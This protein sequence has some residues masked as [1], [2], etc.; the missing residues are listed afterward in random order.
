[1]TVF[2]PIFRG[3]RISLGST[4]G[5][6]LSSH[7]LDKGWW[8][9][10]VVVLVCTPISNIDEIFLSHIAS[11]G[12][13]HRWRF[14]LFEWYKTVLICFSPILERLNSSSCIDWPSVPS[15]KPLFPLWSLSVSY[16]CL[17]CRHVLTDLSFYMSLLLYLF[18]SNSSLHLPVCILC[19]CFFKDPFWCTEI[20]HLSLCS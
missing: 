16:T 11:R 6:T 1:M 8:F 5:Q 10:R 7:R 4:L 13:F 17:F 15:V 3:P 14:L 19:F 12:Y 9:S 2:R 18:M 20:V